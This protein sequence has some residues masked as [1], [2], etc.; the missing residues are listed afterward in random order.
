MLKTQHP[1]DYLKKEGEVTGLPEKQQNSK[2]FQPKSRVRRQYNP[3]DTNIAK[4]FLAIREHKTGNPKINKISEIIGLLDLIGNINDV[5]LNDNSNTPL[6]VAVSKGHEDIVKLLIDKGA[7]IE[8]ANSQNQKPLDI[9]ERLNRQNIVQILKQPTSQSQQ[10]VSGAGEDKE[11]EAGKSGISDQSNSQSRFLSQVGRLNTKQRSA[12]GYSEVNDRL[13]EFVNYFVKEFEAKL[14]AYHMVLEGEVKKAGKFSD[15]FSGKTGK[16]IGG[17]IGGGLGL[18]LTPFVGPAAL[19]VGVTG[20]AA[21]GEEGAKALG[22]K[23]GESYHRNKVINFPSLIYY[24]QKKENKAD[25]RKILIEAGFDIFQS[26]E[27]Q[28][29]RVTTDQGHEGAMRKL[30]ED[31]TNRAIS[32][33]EKKK[34]GLI[35]EGVILG[36]SKIEPVLGVP[37]PTSR[38]KTPGFEINYEYKSSSEKWYTASLYEK[39]GLVMEEKTSRRTSSYHERKDGKSR[40]E[41]YGYRRLFIS[42]SWDKLKEKYK[43]ASIVGS[44]SGQFTDYQYV[45]SSNNLKQQSNDILEK[46][47]LDD[48]DLGEERIKKILEEARGNIIE[49]VNVLKRQSH[50]YADDRKI[51]VSIE[52][53]LKNLKVDEYL[54]EFEQHCEEAKQERQEIAEAVDKGREENRENFDQLHQK[55]GEIHSVVVV[56]QDSKQEKKAVWFDVRNSV[57]FFT[58]LTPGRQEK[59]EQIAS[60]IQEG[61]VVISGLGGVGKSELAVK[62]ARSQY[63]QEDSVIWIN[64]ETREIAKDS[65]HRLHKKLGLKIKDEDGEEKSIEL[66]IEEIYKHL[67]DGKR[68]FIFDNA[69]KYSTIEKFLPLGLPD[70]ANKPYVLIT[71]PNNLEWKSARVNIGTLSLGD[72]TDAE[73]IEFVKT[74]LKIGDD[75]QNVDIINLVKRLHNFPLALQHAVTYIKDASEE[76]QARGSEFKASDYLEKYEQEPKKMLSIKSIDDEHTEAIFKALKITIDKIRDNKEYGQQALDMLNIVSYFMSRNIPEKTFLASGDQEK[77]ISI[78]RLLRKYSIV[79]LEQDMLNVHGLVQQIRRLE[80]ENQQEEGKSLEEKTLE[81]A[82][83]LLKEYVKV[84]SGNAASCIPHIISIWDYASKYDELIKSF[85]IDSTNNKATTSTTY[86]DLIMG[87]FKKVCQA[88]F[89]VQLNFQSIWKENIKLR[90]S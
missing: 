73:A 11:T 43:P 69:E 48:K 24:S 75:S 39:V 84:S 17:A 79:N 1:T 60:S 30:A 83:G 15:T 44:K 29:M 34:E 54:K 71:S 50:G 74:A 64:A 85:I 28:F 51:L 12:T 59:L 89:L 18:L 2:S 82:L 6:H 8:I 45:L 38:I 16:G 31:A 67:N 53:N 81:R 32:Y 5:D 88:A 47:N 7:D 33:L 13:E 72:F 86:F 36:E 61:I 63:S 23:L 49:V 22:N 3:D 78:T 87:T 14:H 55:L 40:A 25:V 4:L 21:L 68:L 41:K 19:R 56:G 42:E 57:T 65:F 27:M 70:N 80:L 90:H 77:L 37:I 76:F 58:A 52:T 9:A 26:F 10:K 46:I 62:Y 66:V 35:T 20:G